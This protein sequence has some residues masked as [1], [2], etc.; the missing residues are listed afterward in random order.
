MNT[1][2]LN[3]ALMRDVVDWINDQL[4]IAH[5]PTER[6]ETARKHPTL[7]PDLIWDQA[8]WADKV[9][10]A[11]CKTS[12]C[13]AGYVSLQDPEVDAAASLRT[14]DVHFK[15]GIHPP[16][17]FHRHAMERLGLT[18]DEAAQLFYSSNDPD[19]VLAIISDILGEDVQ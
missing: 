5:S 18:A 17:S 8:S 9:Y 2:T 4:T 1:P 10:G 3:V 15:D 16:T 19:E 12:C 7:T 14:G 13:I 11:E 6:H